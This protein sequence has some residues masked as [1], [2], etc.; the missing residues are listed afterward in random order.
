MTIGVLENSGERAITAG[1]GR[2]SF[3]INYIHATYDAFDGVSITDGSLQTV[4]LRTGATPFVTGEAQLT[5]TTNTLIAITNIA[6]NR[7]LDAAVAV[8]LVNLRLS[9]THV[10]GTEVTEG[11]ASA[12]GIGDIALR[13]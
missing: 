9:G 6:L 3:G 12:A 13:S 1:E 7:W 2:A 8:P 11:S 4:G 5:I 10:M